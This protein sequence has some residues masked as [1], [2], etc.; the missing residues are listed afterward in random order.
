MALPKFEKSMK[1]L[2][3]I[4]EQME[5]EELTLD[6]S[7]KIFE[8]GVELSKLC[9]DKLD[10]VEQKMQTIVKKSDGFQLELI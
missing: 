6:E 2:E 1:R 4:V 9:H 8:E 5:Q 10:Q 3:E 7:L